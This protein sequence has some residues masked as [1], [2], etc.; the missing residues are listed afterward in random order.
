MGLL[1]RH[2]SQNSLDESNQNPTNH[3]PEEDDFKPLPFKC[4]S[5]FEQAFGI[6]DKL[7]K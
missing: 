4:S 1:L 5:H 6:L 2:A 7:R 3:S